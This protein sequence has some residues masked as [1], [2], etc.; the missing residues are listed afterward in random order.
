QVTAVENRPVYITATSTASWLQV[1][2]PVLAGRSASL[3]LVVPSVPPQPG[4]SLLGRVQIIA[5]GNQ[6]FTVAV[7]LSIAGSTAGARIP[8]PPRIPSVGVP[9]LP[10]IA[11]PPSTR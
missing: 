11:E 2:K 4:E 3:R 7:S 8:P 6:R 5:N 9:A 1:E 10:D